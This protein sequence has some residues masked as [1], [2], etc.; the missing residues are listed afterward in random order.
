[1]DIDPFARYL[2]DLVKNY[3]VNRHG[4]NIMKAAGS[5]KKVDYNTVYRLYRGNQASVSFFMGYRILKVLLP[6]SYKQVLADYRPDEFSVISEFADPDSDPM[7]DIRDK[8]SFVF[9][10]DCSYHIFVRAAETEGMSLSTV[11]KEFGTHGISMVAK[12]ASL[13]IVSVVDSVVFCLLG[14]ADVCPTE[15]ILKAHISKNTE[16]LQL[17]NPGTLLNSAFGGVNDEG[18]KVLFS[19]LSEAFEDV[20]KVLRNSEF[21]GSQMFICSLAGGPLISDKAELQ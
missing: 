1:M 11:E 14:R 12:M 10:S 2:S 19:I 21:R 20:L 16:L 7:D 15:E 17:A 18:M 13:G 4:G 3:V 8:L 5:L 6:N 9:G